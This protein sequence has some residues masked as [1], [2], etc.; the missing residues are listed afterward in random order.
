MSTKTS[1]TIIPTILLDAVPIFEKITNYDDNWVPINTL[2]L[3][4]IDIWGY[5]IIIPIWFTSD[6]HIVC[7]VTVSIKYI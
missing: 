1:T 7:F 3:Y 5:F 4:V 6:K 2:D